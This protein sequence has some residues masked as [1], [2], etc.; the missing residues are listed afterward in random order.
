MF[1]FDYNNFNSFLLTGKKSNNPDSPD[2]VPS[3][4]VHKSYDKRNKS[5]KCE[6][7]DR[8]MKR[9]SIPSSKDVVDSDNVD[10]DNNDEEENEPG[11]MIDYGC[12][13]VMFFFLYK[14]HLLVDFNNRYFYTFAA[15]D[16]IIIWKIIIICNFVLLQY[17]KTIL[18]YYNALCHITA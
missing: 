1:I 3:I 15:S 14:M 11:M 8:V 9:R 18:L 4:F 10:S 5:Q 12:K 17:C 16:Y 13:I 6:R 2:Y 7:Y